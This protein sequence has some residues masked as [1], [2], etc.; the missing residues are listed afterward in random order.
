M[1]RYY[2]AD[3][4]HTHQPVLWWRGHPIWAAHFVAAVFVISLLVTTV[5]VASHVAG[6]MFFWLPF[7]NRLVLHGHVWRLFTYGLV[8]VPSLQFAFDMVYL[9]WFGREVERIFGRKKFLFLFGTIYLLPPAFFTPFGLV[10]PAGRAGET[11]ALAVFVAFA[12]YYP[13]VA[14]FLHLTAKWCA[15]ILVGIFSLMALGA[16]DWSGLIWL[17][18]ACGFAYQWVRHEKG[19]FELPDFRFW[20]RKPRLRVLPDLPAKPAKA[21][22]PRAEADASMAEIDALLDKIAQSGL[23]SL[24]AKERAKLEQGRENLRRKSADR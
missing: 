9:V 21:P 1:S 24:T 23:A 11:G 20:K 16:N 13:E 6:P 15:W 14:I 8:N 4:G 10:W 22:A 12:T 2:A 19:L 17:W 7:D 18:L 3:D 5:L